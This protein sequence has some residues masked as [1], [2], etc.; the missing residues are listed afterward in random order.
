MADNFC[1]IFT[2]NITND[3]RFETGCSGFGNKKEAGRRQKT[4]CFRRPQM[5]FKTQ[6][7]ETLHA[8]PTQATVRQHLEF[9]PFTGNTSLPIQ[10]ISKWSVQPVEV[11]MPDIAQ[12][13]NQ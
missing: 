1:K 12:Y 5:V 4:N 9:T 7:Q 2:G 3:V 10:T 11:E 8:D 6:P 13:F